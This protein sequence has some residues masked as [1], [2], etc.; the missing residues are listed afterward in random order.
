MGVGSGIVWDSEPEAEYAECL[1][2]ARFLTDDPLPDFA[3]LETVR[4]D[5]GYALLDRHLDR[6]RRAAAY[7]GFP[8]DEAVLRDR[9]RETEAR[10]GEVSRVRL[11]LDRRERVE[12]EATPLADLPLVLRRAVVFPEPADSADPFLRHKTTHPR[13]LRPRDAMGDGTRLRRGNPHE[14][15]RRAYRGHAHEPLRPARR[16]AVDTAPRVR[17]AGRRLPR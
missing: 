14:R 5:D 16:P 7:F 1:L 11:T 4:W 15:A 8:F 13:L 2:K 10:L 3:L 9:L 17:R 6:L 12:T